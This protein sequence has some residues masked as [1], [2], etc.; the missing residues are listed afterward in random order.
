MRLILVFMILLATPLMAR[1]L[2]FVDDAQ[3]TTSDL[4][5][6]GKVQGQKF[7]E[8]L[9]ELGTDSVFTARFRVT[10]VQSGNSPSR[11]LTIRYI[12]HTYLSED[13][14]FHFRLRPTSDGTYLVCSEGGRGYVCKQ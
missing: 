9:G 10:R 3:R 1:G 6:F 12:A 11:M 7:I 4:V 14:E 5:V 2:S 13:R 8:T